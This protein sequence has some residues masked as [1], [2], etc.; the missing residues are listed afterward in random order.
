MHCIK[1]SDL[2]PERTHED[3]CMTLLILKILYVLFSTKVTSEYFY[4]N[5]LCVLVDV[6]LRELADLDEEHESV[7]GLRIK[8]TCNNDVDLQLRHTYLRVLHPL[9]TKTQLRDVPYKRPQIL[10]MLESMISNTEIREVSPT[11]NR[12]VERCL[13]GDWCVQLMESRKET[14]KRAA[15]PSSDH[16]S[17]LSP[18]ANGEGFSRHLQVSTNINGAP[19]SLKHSK[20]VE[21]L[22]STR[23]NFPK[24]PLRS[25]LDQ[26]RRPSNASV[27][28]LPDFSNIN[29]AKKRSAT[30]LSETTRPSRHD[31]L[32]TNGEVSPYSIPASPALSTSSVAL[33][34]TSSSQKPLRRPPPAPPR[35]RKPPAIP[36]GHTNGG[37]V[38]ASIRSSEPSPL[39]NSFKPP[40]GVQTS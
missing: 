25:P 11:T 6:F 36:I 40:I 13:S 38:I 17:L 1:V 22:T 28:S 31:S 37:A 12:L 29:G 10:M 16:S 32:V 14:I 4:T 21:N 23:L 27:P 5:D 9:L 20:S 33:E 19:K 15:S 34:S 30:M 2:F 39:S 18:P 8:N 35:R 3:F 7:S 24:P 26:V